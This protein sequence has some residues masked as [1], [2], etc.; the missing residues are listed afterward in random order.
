MP[1]D[2]LPGTTFDVD[3][4][5]ALYLLGRK[6]AFGLPLS[7]K[8]GQIPLC[9]RR[10][11][12]TKEV[13]VCCQ[14]TWTKFVSLG[15][16]TATPNSKEWQLTK[17]G[18]TAAKSIAASLGKRV[19]GSMK[20]QGLSET[21][22]YPSL[23]DEESPLAWLAR[24]KGRDGKPMVSRQQFAAGERLRMDYYRANL[25][26]KVTMDWSTA[27]TGNLSRRHGYGTS[28]LTMSETAE[29]ARACVNNAL[30][31][32]GPELAS[33]LVD[34]C[35]HLKGLEVTEQDSGWPRRSGKVIL[36]L[37]LSSLARHY[38]FVAE[39]ATGDGA[40]T[41]EI[42]HWGRDGYRPRLEVDI[43]PQA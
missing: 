9:R 26:A 18:R 14:S 27:L 19:P 5:Q 7:A 37:A 10:S 17:A 22:A 6:G 39:D 33:I 31:A 29:V 42:R 13:A 32:V 15:L 2:G 21:G 16:V 3:A 30:A 23:N 11:A 35:C 28:G 20:T 36:L 25:N 12:G 43:E 34:V 24:R 1:A 8:H 4:R 40:H 38:G 41:S